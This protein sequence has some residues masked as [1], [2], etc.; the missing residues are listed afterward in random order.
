V[1][2]KRAAQS[3]PDREARARRIRRK[4]LHMTGKRD[5][6]KRHLRDEPTAPFPSD[7]PET[8]A[9]PTT[10]PANERQKRE[11]ED[12]ES[13]FPEPTKGGDRGPDLDC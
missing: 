3:T 6:R 2:D 13:A 9:H 10:R 8:T 11:R 4:E 7:A 1:K 5:K 12:A